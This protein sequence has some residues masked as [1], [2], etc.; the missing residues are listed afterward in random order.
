VCSLDGSLAS[1]NVDR[2]RR[3]TASIDDTGR[4]RRESRAA[5]AHASQLPISRRSMCGV[6]ATD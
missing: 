3:P 5:S 6:D 2:R 1:S 4:R